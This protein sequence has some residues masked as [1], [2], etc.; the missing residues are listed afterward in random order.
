MRK[1]IVWTATLL[2]LV[3]MTILAVTLSQQST[4]GGADLDEADEVAVAPDGSVYLTGTT[5]SFGAGGRDAFLL[6]Y[7]PNGSLAWQRTYG[8]APTPLTT[9]DEFG[10][11]VAAAPDGSAYVT[12]QFGEGN[13][14]LTK[15]DPNG[16][17]LWQQ[18]WGTNGNVANA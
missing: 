13:L 11:G 5:L 2:I 7:A 12:G 18:T 8:T 10:L 15:F 4:W 9:G 17:L 3:Q 14:F 16:N 1:S 6:K